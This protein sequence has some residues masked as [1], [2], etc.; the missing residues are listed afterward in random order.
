MTVYNGMTLSDWIQWPGIR[1]L[2]GV[3]LNA[4]FEQ[5]NAEQNA[6]ILGLLRLTEDKANSPEEM[7]E[8]IVNAVEN[9]NWNNGKIETE[10]FPE[11]ADVG[12]YGTASLMSVRIYPEQEETDKPAFYLPCSILMAK[13]DS[14]SYYVVGCSLGNATEIEASVKSFRFTQP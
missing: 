4:K 5:P 11:P 14:V 1:A 2:V 6:Y 8:T 7:A 13:R 12:P 10:R 3:D 9:I